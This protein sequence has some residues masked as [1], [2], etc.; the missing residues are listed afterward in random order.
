MDEMMAKKTRKEDEWGRQVKEK[1][2]KLTKVDIILAVWFLIAIFQVH[3]SIILFFSVTGNF[4]FWNGG[5]MFIEG[6][7]AILCYY[8]SDE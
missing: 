5:L 2:D 7:I 8:K 6:M 3:Y 1:K 4:F